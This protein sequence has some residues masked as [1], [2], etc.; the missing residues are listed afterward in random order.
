MAVVLRPLGPS[1][2]NK[3]VK[4]QVETCHILRATQL[5]LDEGSVALKLKQNLFTEI[6]SFIPVQV[7][8]GQ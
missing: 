1:A 3:S 4:T 6:V 8:I 7:K 5:S 2:Y